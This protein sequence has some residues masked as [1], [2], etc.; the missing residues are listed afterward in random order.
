MGGGRPQ[1]RGDLALD[2]RAL[3]PYRLHAAARGVSLVTIDGLSSTWDADLDSSGRA[4]DAWLQ[5]GARLVRGVYTRD[6]SLLSMARCRGRGPRRRSRRAACACSS[7][8]RL[9]D[10]P[11]ATRPRTSAPAAP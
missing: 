11:R 2:G 6:L 5:G 7:A 3:G 1:A 10:N 4:G 8:M 9:D